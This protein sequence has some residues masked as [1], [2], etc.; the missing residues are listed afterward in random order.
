[1]KNEYE[2]EG[3][4]T[5][6]FIDSKTYGRQ[7][8]LIDTDDLTKVKKINSWFVV[9]DKTIDSFYVTGY[10]KRNGAWNKLKMHRYI[11]GVS[12]PETQ[13][14][15][16]NHNPLD[17]R[18]KMMRVVEAWQNSQNRNKRSDNKSGVP[19]VFWEKSTKSWTAQIGVKG[20]RIHLGRFKSFESAVKVRKD[21]EK[22]LF[23]Y[24]NSLEQSCDI[25]R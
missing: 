16:I 9:Y 19:G 8:V 7:E 18:K 22:R 15:H 6:I 11:L 23:N 14:D 12:D 1:M 25:G 5:R 20:R 2:I 24:K 21:A 4:I 10:L 13:V 17:N 3:K